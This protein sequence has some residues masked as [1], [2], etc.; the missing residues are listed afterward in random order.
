MPS[1]LTKPRSIVFNISNVV[2]YFG[3]LHDFHPEGV[4]RP[5]VRAHQG[6]HP[7]FR[8]HRH[9]PDDQGP[10]LVAA[11]GDGRPGRHRPGV[12]RPGARSADGR[13]DHR[14]RASRASCACR[15]SPSARSSSTPRRRP[16]TGATPSSGGTGKLLID[17]TPAAIGPYVVP[18]VNLDEHLDADNVN[19]VTLRG[20]GD[21]PDRRRR[22]PGRAGALRRDRRLDRLE[23]GRARAPG[24]T[25]TSSPRPPPSASSRSAARE[26]GKAIIVLNPAEPPLIMRDTVYCLVRSTPT[27]TRSPPPSTRMVDEVAQYVPGYRLKQPVQVEPVGEGEPCAIPDMDRKFDGHQGERV[28]RGRGRR[29]LPAGLRRQPRHHD[30]GGAADRRTPGDRG[31]AAE[32]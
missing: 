8:Q 13:G 28:P 31:S 30:V 27:T 20:P 15:S 6:G 7:R 1:E 5:H 25:S 23:V 16:P 4:M 14:A 24:R 29:P 9:R 22:Q 19:M 26:R 18:V 12:R 10:A 11:P 21:D 3:G 32:A 2:R 17:L